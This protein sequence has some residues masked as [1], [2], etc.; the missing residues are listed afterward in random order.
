M[1]T[2]RVRKIC[3]LLVLIF[4]LQS[5]NIQVASHCAVEE[6]HHIL[7]CVFGNP[8]INNILKNEGNRINWYKK[9]NSNEKINISAQVNTRMFFK[10]A[11]LEFWP[12]TLNDSGTYY[13]T[14]QNE[15]HEISLQVHKKYK[16][17]CF[18]SSCQ[19]ELRCVTGSHVK[20]QLDLH[21]YNAE[22]YYIEWYK[23]CQLY[24][25]NKDV[26]FDSVLKS[27]EG[28]YTSVIILEHQGKKYNVSRKTRLLVEEP[29]EVLQ[30]YIKGSEDNETVYIELGQNVTLK[31]E[32]YGLNE[33]IA[34][35]YWI[36]GNDSVVECT[37]YIA[38]KC[39]TN[40]VISNTAISE[41][42][43][44]NINEDDIKNPYICKLANIYKNQWKLFFLKIKEK[45]QDISKGVFTTSMAASITSI[46]CIV[47]L[48]VVCL[49]FRIEIILLY[50][51]ITGKDETIQDGK[52]FDA[53]FAFLNNSVTE[54]E[55]EREF[56]FHI[57]P[58][59]MESHFGYKLCI[60]ERDTLPG[61]AIVDDVHSF[62]EKSR[63]LIILLSR[64]LMFDKV[65]YE[66]EIGL[67]KA[68]VE[69]KIKVILIEY[70]PLCELNVM[71]AS[72]KLLKAS[73]RVKWKGSRSQ[74]LKSRFWKK[75]QYL[76]PAK[77]VK[78]L[79]KIEQSML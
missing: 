22:N 23:D 64:N 60:R 17:N 28:N 55:D 42:H 68:M 59:V 25:T 37:D 29:I 11:T 9:T 78:P 5:G 57:L 41:L 38:T 18:H 70:A 62:L 69:R 61:G 6:E 58:R 43:L 40:N 67:Y 65:I 35:L 14:F 46:L 48:M 63:R 20:I 66:L 39:C 45:N 1:E 10:E 47:I 53:Y 8:T 33:E 12:I 16:D 56:A 75:I 71:P 32:A 21:E 30:P 36:H 72:L 79:S 15:S 54:N 19:R 13:C 49:W 44:F 7:T 76:M 31:C 3:F 50:R 26:A 27:D 52:E 24:I 2:L 77:P 34:D 74:P 73:K 51:T 4:Q